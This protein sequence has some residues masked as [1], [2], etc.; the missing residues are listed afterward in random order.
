MQ[1]FGVLG[2]LLCTFSMACLF[3]TYSVVGEIAFAISLIAMV[4][5]LLLSLYEISISV[6][7]LN[8]ELEQMER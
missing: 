3:F 4:I 2:F 6:N 5:S 7:V 1:F 8:I